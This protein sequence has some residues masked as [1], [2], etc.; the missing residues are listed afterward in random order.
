MN[1]SGNA[2]SRDGGLRI[3]FATGGVFA[4]LSALGAVA[5]VCIGMVTGGTVAALPHD[6]VGRFAQLAATPALG[7]YNL[8]LL[9]L[10]TTLMMVAVLYACWLA[11]RQESQAA[12]L[13]LAIG[14]VGAAIFAANNS[15]L[16][17]LGLARD[18]ASADAARKNLLA[19]AG[20][21]LLAKGAHG[22]PGVLAGFLLSA[23]ANLLLAG[24][25]LRTRIFSRIT[26]LFGLCGNALLGIYL[27]LVTLLPQVQ[28]KAIAFAVPGG[29]MA[30]GW[31]TMVAAGLFGMTRTAPR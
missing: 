26:G 22:S 17:M 5:D 30:I 13:A 9:N 31:L 16:A 7:L 25:M 12:G 2:L 20:E 18:F 23:T 8:D 27:V 24:S 11:L 28:G 1:E 3:M 4:L 29:L 6:A 19:A 15:A 14:V 21:A 10:V